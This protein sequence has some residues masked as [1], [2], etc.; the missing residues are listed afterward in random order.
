MML[1]S[2]VS[3]VMEGRAHNVQLVVG[4]VQNYEWYQVEVYQHQ[5]LLNLSFD[6]FR[7][8]TPFM[9]S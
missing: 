9:I 6:K 4:I 8:Q 3:G 5:H 2:G 1:L 7:L